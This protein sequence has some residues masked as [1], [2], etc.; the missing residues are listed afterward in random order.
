LKKR[1]A[2]T[3]KYSHPKLNK[4][5]D[6]FFADDGVNYVYDHDTLHTVVAVG[7][8]PAYMEYQV[9]GADVLCSKEKFF[10]VDEHTRLYGVYEEACVLAIERAVIPYNTDPDKAFEI[11]LEK[12]CTS[13]TSGWFREF[14][15]ENYDQVL[16]MHQ[17]ATNIGQGYYKKFKEWESSNGKV[18]QGN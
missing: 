12:V 16:V 2:E 15:W 9:E 4:A 10:S 5:K 18:E 7:D 8:R 6:Q 11:A 17:M 3:Y 1:A 13:I 14:A